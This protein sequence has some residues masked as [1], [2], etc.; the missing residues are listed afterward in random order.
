LLIKG[1]L[2]KQW[3]LRPSFCNIGRSHHPTPDPVNMGLMTLPLFVLYLLS[4]VF[5][6]AAW[7][8]QKETAEEGTD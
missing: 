3:A 4:I 5:A 8:P 2:A 1:Q 7:R 6:Y